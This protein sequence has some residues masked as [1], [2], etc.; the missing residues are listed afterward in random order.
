M[1]QQVTLHRV[2]G[3]DVS[4]YFGLQDPLDRVRLDFNVGDVVT[5]RREG[6]LIE[7]AVEDIR[8]YDEVDTRWL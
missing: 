3:C 7:V 4:I 1:R 8:L 6:E 2:A 5:I